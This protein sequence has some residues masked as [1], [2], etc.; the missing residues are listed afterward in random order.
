MKNPTDLVLLQL[1]TARK[2]SLGQGNIF[3]RMFLSVGGGS[4]YDVTSCL[5][6]WS[7][8]PSRGSLVTCSFGGTLSW[9]GGSVQGDCQEEPPSPSDRGPLYGE[10]RAVSILLEYFLWGKVIFSQA[11]VILF[12]GE[13]SASV[14]AGIPSP[15]GPGA[16]QDQAPPTPR[17][18]SML[19]DTVN[20]RAVRILLEC[21]FVSNLSA[22]SFLATDSHLGSYYCPQMKF[23]AR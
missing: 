3:R 18:Q 19:G 11:S 10:E 13:D 2:R 9:G 21:N 14:H 15:P 22:H 17:A 8:V 23:G 12:T 5:A 4:L 1:I 7:H 6:A 16:P 20:A